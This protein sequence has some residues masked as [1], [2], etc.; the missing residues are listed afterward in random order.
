MDSLLNTARSSAEVKFANTTTA[1]SKSA[2]IF[3]HSTKGT[4]AQTEV[5]NKLQWKCRNRDEFAFNRSSCKF[6]K[7]RRFFNT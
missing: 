1:G 5:K 4:S 6:R 7:C 3:T 2:I